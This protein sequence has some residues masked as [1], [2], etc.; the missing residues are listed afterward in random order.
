V[1]TSLSA[2]TLVE[3]LVQELDQLPASR[4]AALQV[5]R[6]VDDPN[7]GA[8]DV[9]KAAGMDPALTAR[10]LRVANSVYYGLSGRVGTPSFAITVIGFQTV[11]SL[12]AVAAAG[13]T[14]PDAL[15][16]GFWQRATAV[17]SGTSLVAPRVRAAAP[18]AFCAGLLHDLGDALLRQHDRAAH[19]RVLAGIAARPGKWARTREE[20]RAYGGSHAELCA[21]VLAAWHFPAELC[22]AIAG[23][24]ADPSRTHPPLQRALIAG[25]VLADLAQT[26]AKPTIEQQEAL[27]AASVPAQDVLALV[28]EVIGA[29]D[30]LSAAFSA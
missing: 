11:R 15:P 26:G 23:H 7:A 24:H 5:V 19:D 25:Q 8:A 16:P 30:A 14:S 28:E 21:Q 1:T 3:R 13:L 12:A 18:E 17:A 29:R 22:E 27:N 9:S 4:G 6:V 10:I 2:P 20:L